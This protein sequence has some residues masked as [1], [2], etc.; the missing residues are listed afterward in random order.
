MIQFRFLNAAEQAAKKSFQCWICNE[1]TTC[2]MRSLPPE[3]G[4]VWL[5][6]C[7]AHVVAAIELETDTAIRR[8]ADIEH[9]LV[10]VNVEAKSG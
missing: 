10:E 9:G 3:L 7:R 1:Y 8:A 6:V 2:Q 5:P 4:G